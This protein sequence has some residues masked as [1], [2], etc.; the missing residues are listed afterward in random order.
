MSPSRIEKISFMQKRWRV[1]ISSFAEATEISAEELAPLSPD[2]RAAALQQCLH[3]DNYLI[4]QV[5]REAACA[6]FSGEQSFNSR[7]EFMEHL[8][9]LSLRL[10]LQDRELYQHSL[11]VLAITRLF[12]QALHLPTEIS[13]LIQ[14]AAFFHDLGKIDIS[15]EILYKPAELT[16]Q[17]FEEVK[18]HSFHGAQRLA[19]SQVLQVAA[20]MVYHNHEHWDGS[21]YPSGLRGLSIP[22]GSRIIAIA[23]AFVVITTGRAYQSPSTPAQALEELSR[24]AGAQFDPLLVALFCSYLQNIF[25]GQQ[26]V[27]FSQL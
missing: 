21:G 17:E 27:Q 5:C 8:A 25:H 24:C 1:A 11:Q 10:Q 4:N 12:L 7:H 2:R 9:I 19:R 6:L 20:N 18:K 16:P 14:I 22:L 3:F 26:A 23:D 13:S 15:P